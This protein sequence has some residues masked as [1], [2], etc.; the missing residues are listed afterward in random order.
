MKALAAEF[1][2]AFALVFIGCGAIMVD[3]LTGALGHLGVSLAF[4]LVIA[5]MIYA[6]GH[7]SGAHFN[8]AV[9]LALAATRRFAPSAVPGYITAQVAGA[10]AAA[11][12]LRGILGPTAGLGSTSATDLVAPAGA[13][14]VEVV[15]TFLL[16]YVIVGVT[17]RG[18]HPGAAGAAIG[19]TV[20]LAALVGGPLTGA[21]LNPARSI[22]P[23]LASGDPTLI[24]ALPLYVLAPV[25]G[26][27]LGALAHGGRLRPSQ[28]L[29]AEV[30]A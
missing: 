25:V 14:A 10:L 15:L 26:G 9:T 5:A 12:A 30:A 24:A 11:A 3:S 20:A 19:A 13:F 7:V 18:A 2:G 27:L 21:S 17:S 28:P 6:V 22:G 23:A 16:V 29:P 4:G 1:A 8:P